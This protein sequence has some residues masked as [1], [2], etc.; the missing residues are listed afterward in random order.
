[1]SDPPVILKVSVF[2]EEVEPAELNRKM[3]CPSPF[4]LLRLELLTVIELVPSITAT[5]AFCAENVAPVAVID[6][7]E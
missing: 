6:P 1:M 7:V 3:A 2:A 4:A 5:G